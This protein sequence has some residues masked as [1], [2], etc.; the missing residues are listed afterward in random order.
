MPWSGQCKT[1]LIFWCKLPRWWVWGPEPHTQ[2]STGLL[3]VPLRTG[4]L[5]FGESPWRQWLYLQYLKLLWTYYTVILLNQMSL[6]QSSLH[7]G[8]GSGVLV[9]RFHCEHLSEG[10]FVSKEGLRSFPWPRYD[11]V[12]R[13][14]LRES[15]WNPR[16]LQPP[17]QSAASA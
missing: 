15:W 7:L 3:L 11:P 14:A 17:S 12:C 4:T 9:F 1:F 10:F 13:P 8:E 5:S 2:V 6:K 16:H